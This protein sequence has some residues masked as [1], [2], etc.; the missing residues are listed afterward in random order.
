VSP[1]PLGRRLLLLGG[2]LLAL[3]VVGL[4]YALFM[5]PLSCGT[6]A[7]S[8]GTQCKVLQAITWASLVGLPLAAVLAVAGAVIWLRSPASG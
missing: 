8:A 2:A 3:S 4:F 5:G 6:A 1:D 7:L